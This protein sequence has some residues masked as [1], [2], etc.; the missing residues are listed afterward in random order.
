LKSILLMPRTIKRLEHR[1]VELTDLMHEVNGRIS[2]DQRL[3][4]AQVRE[5]QRKVIHELDEMREQAASRDRQVQWV[6]ARQEERLGALLEPQAI[7]AHNR[8]A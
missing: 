1:T 4:L 6:M 8:A 7:H 3:A 5:S 2:T